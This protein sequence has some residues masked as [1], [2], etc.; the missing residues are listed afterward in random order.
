MNQEE[1]EV[2]QKVDENVNISLN[3]NVPLWAGWV[4][5]GLGWVLFMATFN[6]AIEIFTGLLCIGCVYLGYKH[7]QLKTPPF[8]GWDNLSA[9]NLIYSSAFEALWMFAWG[10]GFFDSIF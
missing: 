8:L 1:K 7:N 6:H 5:N 4:I 9:K 2:E 3:F 10:F